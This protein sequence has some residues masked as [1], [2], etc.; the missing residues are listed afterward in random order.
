MEAGFW[1]SVPEDVQKVYI[2][3]P[4]MFR[5]PALDMRVLHAV[6]VPGAQVIGKVAILRALHVRVAFAVAVR[7]ALV[8]V[9]RALD[10]RVPLAVQAFL[11]RQSIQLDARMRCA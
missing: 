1:R 7:G 5:V 9:L 6:A 8:T 2:S 10:V 11:V 3:A 4:E